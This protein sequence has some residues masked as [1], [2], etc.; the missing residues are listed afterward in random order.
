MTA[1]SEA[2]PYCGEP[3]SPVALWSHWRLDPIVLALLV[4]LWALY[5]IGSHRLRR[6]APA[7]APTPGQRTAFHA[8][9]LMAA[10][11]LVSPLCPL[12]VSLFAARVS[13]HIV[14]T[15][16]AAPLVASGSPVRCL[17][18][19]VRLDRA[20]DGASALRARAPL[21]AAATLA[22]LI[23]LWH[24]P[25]VYEATFRSVTTYWLM[26]LSLFASALWLWTALLRASATQAGVLSGLLASILSS[27]QMGLLGA[28]IT[29]APRA[30]YGAHFLTTAAWGLTP[31]EDQ[32]L[33]GVVMWVPGCGVF[34]V[35]AMIGA[36]RCVSTDHG[37]SSRV[38]QRTE[39][40][41]R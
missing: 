14:L 12:S 38:P 7:D 37:P 3:P 2:A 31:L 24:A 28:V 35:V 19:A 15:M 1:M 27:A 33:G 39:G 4:G 5:W 8:G 41:V 18:C 23:W 9:W 11:A 25:A 26:H 32:Q 34:L 21:A 16:F 20:A 17:A 13:Q 36:A 40:F 29:L 30:L 10:L 6:L 22:V